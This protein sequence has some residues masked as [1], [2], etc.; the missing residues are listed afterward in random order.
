LA[1]RSDVTCQVPVAIPSSAENTF[2]VPA[3]Y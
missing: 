2:R 1:S 3:K